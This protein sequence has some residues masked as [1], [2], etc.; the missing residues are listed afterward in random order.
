MVAT[1]WPWPPGFARQYLFLRETHVQFL[2]N[3]WESDENGGGESG[4]EAVGDGGLEEYLLVLG[5]KRKEEEE[6]REVI[7][8]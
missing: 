2:E 5:F 6:A 3:L 1:S 7:T 4:S 8:E